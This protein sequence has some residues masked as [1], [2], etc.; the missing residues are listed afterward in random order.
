M[1]HKI[2]IKPS[3]HVLNVRS[4]ETILQAALREGLSLPYGCRNGSCGACKGKITQG[5]V[6][7][8]QYDEDTLTEKEKQ[9]GMALFCCAKPRSDLVIE[10]QEISTI[11]DIEIKTLPCRVQKL[12]LVAPDVMV[13]SLKLPPSQR[14]QFLAGQYIDILLKDGKRRSFSLANAPHNDEYLQLHCRNYQI[15][16]AHV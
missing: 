5:T 10:C 16:R 9:N 3:D 7:F 4:D 14:L 15:G 6:V 13:L 11:K 1:S 2:I 12:E 8:G